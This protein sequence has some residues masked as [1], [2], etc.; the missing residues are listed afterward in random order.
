M[1]KK[2]A[3]ALF[4]REFPTQHIFLAQTKVGGGEMIITR[5]VR[6]NAGHVLPRNAPPPLLLNIDDNT[7]TL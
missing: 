6:R 2:A 3:G 1:A 5:K 4:I 7:H